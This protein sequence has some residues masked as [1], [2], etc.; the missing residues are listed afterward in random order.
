MAVIA[1]KEGSPGGSVSLCVQCKGYVKFQTFHVI[2]WHWS[3]L[4]CVF[5][6]KL[7]EFKLTRFGLGGWGKV[8]GCHLRN[9]QVLRGG[10]RGGLKMNARWA[11]LYWHRKTKMWSPHRCRR[12]EIHFDCWRFW[13]I[14]GGATSGWSAHSRCCCC[15]CYYLAGIHRF[16]VVSVSVLL[17]LLLRAS[18]SEKK[19]SI[20]IGIERKGKKSI[21]EDTLPKTQVYIQ[22]K[23]AGKKREIQM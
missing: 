9:F 17:L 21:E 3:E 19:K 5:F 7:L 1:S 22:S 23:R 6:V 13:P 16:R 10:R 18:V 20:R 2:R 12:G 15:C 14:C 8:D 11:G 4:L